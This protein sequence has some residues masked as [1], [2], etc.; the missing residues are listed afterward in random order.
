MPS[1]GREFKSCRAR[2][3]FNSLT[4]E[5]R[6]G[7]FLSEREVGDSTLCNHPQQRPT[8]AARSRRPKAPAPALRPRPAQVHHLLLAQG[9]KRP[10]TRGEKRMKLRS[11]FGVDPPSWTVEDSAC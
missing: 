7:R 11:A 2:Q 1:G 9:G 10:R 8:P 4:A 6:F 3:Y 5:P